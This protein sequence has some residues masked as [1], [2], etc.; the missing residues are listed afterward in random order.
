[1]EAITIVLIFYCCACDKQKAFITKYIN[2]IDRAIQSI[3]L[4][5]L[6]VHILT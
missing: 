6:T 2:W 3:S 1:M 4:P 5:I